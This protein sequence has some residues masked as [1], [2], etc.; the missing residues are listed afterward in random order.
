MEEQ[1]LQLTDSR[2]LRDEAREELL[3]AQQSWAK[4]RSEMA[5]KL[6]QE[7]KLQQTETATLTNKFESRLRVQEESTKAL[8]VQLTSARRERDVA[9]EK[10]ASADK[11]VADTKSKLEEAERSIESKLAAKEQCAQEC[12]ELKLEMTKL[13]TDI[14]NGVKE[15]VI[16]KEMW[17][18]ERDEII[19]KLP[20]V[21][22][23]SGI[24]KFRKNSGHS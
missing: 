18:V 8:H 3:K 15:H 19:S 12:A 23:F 5:H 13:K 9:K 10:I 1:R 14:D 20:K 16:D 4:E 6:R 21:E 22:F 17:K 24:L 2:K 11:L 7:E